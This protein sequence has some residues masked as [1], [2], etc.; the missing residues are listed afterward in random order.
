M[1]ARPSEE[2]TTFPSFSI[3]I[4][5]TLTYPSNLKIINV[6]LFPRSRN[7]YKIAHTVMYYLRVVINNFVRGLGEEGERGGGERE[8]ERERFYF[9]IR[10]VRLC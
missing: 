10:E 7:V 8:K 6:L 2:S 1:A 5:F 3:P 9:V 4:Y